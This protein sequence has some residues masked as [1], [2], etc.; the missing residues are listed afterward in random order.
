MFDEAQHEIIP[1]GELIGWIRRKAPAGGR[2]F[3]IYHHRIHGTFVVGRWAQDR[4]M[5]I[6][7]D[8]LNLGHSINMTRQQAAEFL[9]RLYCPMSPEEMSRKIEQANRDYTTERIN[10]DG[11]E[12]DRKEELL[13]NSD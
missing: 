7:T 10:G 9:H 13:A 1:G 6:F 12:Y 2:D 11:E 3:F 5:G 8:F 4:E